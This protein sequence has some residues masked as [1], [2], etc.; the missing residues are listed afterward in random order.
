MKRLMNRI[1]AD[2]KVL[3]IERIPYVK[4]VRRSRSAKEGSYGK[5]YLDRYGAPG[6]RAIEHVT[7]ICGVIP[8]LVIWLYHSFRHPSGIRKN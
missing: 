1:Q 2:K 6:D 4:L 5:L 8:D 7:R 3:A